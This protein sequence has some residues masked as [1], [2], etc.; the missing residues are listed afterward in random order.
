[1]IKQIKSKKRVS[2]YGEVYTAAREVNAMLDLVGN[3]ANEITTTFLEPACGNGNF[4]VAILERKLKTI[5]LQHVN[6]FKTS[7]NI[8]RSVASIYGVDIQRDNVEE[9]KSRMRAQAD[10]CYKALRCPTEHFYE[11]WM[12]VL[13]LILETNILCG[14]SLTAMTLDGSDL[15]FSEWNISDN[16]Y[17]TRDEVR[18]QDMLNGTDDDS[19]KHIKYYYDVNNYICRTA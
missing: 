4:I 5:K 11:A 7:M 16:G 2:T 6:D 17:I 8:L 3:K 12:Q 13:E 15:S 19:T 9:T 14:N 1:M 18:F 10:A